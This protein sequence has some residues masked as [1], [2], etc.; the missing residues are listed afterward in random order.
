MDFN[1]YIKPILEHK[2]I[3]LCWVIAGLVI[4][5]IAAFVQKPVYITKTKWF[6]QKA[7]S[8]SVL[9]GMGKSS[10]GSM[11]ANAAGLL[12]GGDSGGSAGID[13]AILQSPEIV[14]AIIEEAE[15]KNKDGSYISVGTFRKRFKVEIDKKFPFINI[16]YASNDANESYNVL[17][18]AE[19]VF[20]KKNITAEAKKAKLNREFIENQVESA[21]FSSVEAADSLKNYEKRAKVVNIEEEAKQQQ[22]RL[23]QLEND[24]AEYKARLASISTKTGDLKRKLGVSSTRLAI[25]KST[26][27]SDVDITTLKD[28]LLS[29]NNELIALKVKYTDKHHAIIERQ[30]EIERLKKEIEKRQYSLIGKSVPA[31]K[32]EEIKNVKSQMI[33]NLVSYSTE[34]VALKS[35]IKAIQDT[36]GSYNKD[37][38]NLPTKKYNLTRLEFENEFQKS[39]LES[40]KQSYETAKINEEFAKNTIS[41]VKLDEPLFPEKPTYPNIYLNLIIGL[42]ASLACAYANILVLEKLDHQIRSPKFLEEIDNCTYLGQINCPSSKNPEDL[43]LKDS[44]NEEYINLRTNMKFLNIDDKNKNITFLFPESQI[45]SSAVLTNLACSLAKANN[46]TLII[47]ANFREPILH[48]IMGLNTADNGLSD[49]LAG[50]VASHFEIIQKLES[51]HNLSYMPAGILPPNPSDILDS[52]KMKELIDRLSDE[53]DFVL[54]NLP[55]FKDYADSLIVSS[56]LNANIIVANSLTTNLNEFKHMQNS[57]KKHKIDVLGSVLINVD[58]KA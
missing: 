11:L 8:G 10:E 17:L 20:K 45:Y 13:A 3:I 42:V 51:L 39:R 25:E 4:A 43:L 7:S 5:V 40:I 36:L 33:D 1:K 28:K 9:S 50:N 19:E 34:E 54:Y 16:E 22:T 35:R 14:K 30:E 23:L 31:D 46:K 55:A 12:L 21:E 41:I 18:I 37:L 44:N 27:G 24:L 49:Y 38:R 48:K 47:E 6:I 57:L 2:K 58:E 26:I 29:K 15:I 53:Y 32:I 52:A 56:N